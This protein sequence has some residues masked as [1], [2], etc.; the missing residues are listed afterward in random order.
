MSKDCI[1]FDKLN[2][3]KKNPGVSEKSLRGGGVREGRD[4]EKNIKGANAI[5]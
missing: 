2:I 3:T 5:S 1:H 4:K